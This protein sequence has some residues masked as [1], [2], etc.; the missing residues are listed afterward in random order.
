MAVFKPRCF[1]DMG[2]RGPERALGEGERLHFHG[3]WGKAPNTLLT[4][5]EH[6]RAWRK[7]GSRWYLIARRGGERIPR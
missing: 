4:K 6:P 5:S 7:Q 2:G 3:I 1:L